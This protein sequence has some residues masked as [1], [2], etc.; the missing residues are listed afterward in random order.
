MEVLWRVFERR[1]GALTRGNRAARS[2]AR[3]LELA[4]VSVSD[5]PIGTLVM[6]EN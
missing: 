6:I 1:T 5:T 2:V 4:S 3:D